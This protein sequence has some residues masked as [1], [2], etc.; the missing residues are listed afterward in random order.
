MPAHSQTE[1]NGILKIVVLYAIYS[2]LYIL[3]SDSLVRSLF[4]DPEHITTASIAKGWLFVLI[5]SAMLY[6]FIRRLLHR[7]LAQLQLREEAYRNLTEYSP[8]IIYQA[9]LEATG[10]TTYISARINSLGYTPDEWLADPDIWAKHLHPDDLARVIATLERS[11]RLNSLFSCKYRLKTKQGEWRHFNDEARIIVNNKGEP[12]YLQGMMIDVTDRV[13]AERELRVAATAFASQDAMFVTDEHQV[14]LKVN[15]AFTHITGYSVQESV[16]Q[17]PALLKSG[18]QDDQFYQSMW[19]SLKYHHYWFGEIWNRRKNGEVYP[20]WLSISAVLDDN[21]RISH[22]VAS[23]SD[24]SQRKRAE[25]TIHFL[26]YYDSLTGLPN[27]KKLLEH[28][29]QLS[30]ANLQH[31]H[32]FAILHIGIDDFKKLNDTRGHDVG[33]LF[34]IEVTKRIKTC[35]QSND[36]VARVGGDEFIVLLENLSNEAE[37]L[38][39]QTLEI[40]GR[41]QYSINQGVQLL[42]IEHHF[43]AS[44]GITVFQDSDTSVE[45]LL[46]RADSAMHQAKQVG[47]DQVNFFDPKLQHALEDR[48]LLESMLRSAIPSQLA[49]HYQMQIGRENQTTGVEALLRWQHPKRGMISPAEFIPLAEESGLIIP[50]GHWVTQR[51]CQQLKA[52]ENNPR[53]QHLTMAINVSAKQLAQ[54][55]FVDGILTALQLT[56][57]NPN[58]LKLELTESLLVGEIDNIIEKMTLLKAK[59]MHFSLDDF[60]TGYSSLSYLKRLPIDQLKIDQSFVCD[61]L[62]D[63]N[64]AAI[65]RTIIALGQTLG[66]GVIA[67]GVETEEQRAF[68]EENHCYHYQG[69]LINKPLAIDAL[70]SL[71]GLNISP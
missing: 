19:D 47:H 56:G 8:A 18:L 64:D 68:L 21:Q 7:G 29:S 35:L 31:H 39:K 58:L 3:V 10:K 41:L 25:E 26:S 32:V 54:P 69:Y 62:T 49:L 6:A 65:A 33:D 46:K 5:T 38:A 52:W 44:I 34:L 66:I 36:T 57:A 50:I 11:L 15:K 63:S 17:T 53:T 28:L 23:F 12:Q 71:F 67:E 60:G 16:G 24:I 45:E 2:A 37:I 61:V 70:E 48:V 14:I 1:A 22:Y 43:T 9:S 27:R 40:A 20:Q 55:D 4:Q 30:I 59:G 13:I 42:G 51:A